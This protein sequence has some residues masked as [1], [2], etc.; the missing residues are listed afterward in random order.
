[1]FQ[2]KKYFA[3]VLHLGRNSPFSWDLLTWLTDKQW[4]S[5]RGHLA[6]CWCWCWCWCCCLLAQSCL[7]LLSPMDCSMPDFPVLHQLRVCSS[8]CP[9]SWIGDIVQPSHPLSPSSPPVFHLSQHQGLF[10]W[11]G[12][13]H[14]MAKVLELQHQSFQWVFRVDFL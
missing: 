1:M 11:V 6:C 13:S 7:T 3:V 5:K 8:S 2:D 9:L 4:L 12:S 10:H 14:Q